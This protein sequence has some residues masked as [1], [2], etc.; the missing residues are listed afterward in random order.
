[1]WRRKQAWDEYEERVAHERERSEAHELRNQA[2][3]KAYD[4]LLVRQHLQLDKVDEILDRQA[5]AIDRWSA[6]A[7]QLENFVGGSIPKRPSGED[8]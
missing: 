6:L 2:Q 7:E 1:M 3:L 5:Q 4:D 8:T